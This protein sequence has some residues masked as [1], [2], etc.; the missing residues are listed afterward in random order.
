MAVRFRGIDPEPFI[1]RIYPAVR[2]LFS[3]WTIAACVSLAI[4]AVVCVANAGAVDRSGV[5]VADAERAARL[6]AL[7]LVRSVQE[8]VV[9]QGHVAFLEFQEDGL[10]RRRPLG[11]RP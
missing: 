10:L 3:P 1:A 8:S 2:C 4:A 7:I 6:V 9:Q 5:H 11:G